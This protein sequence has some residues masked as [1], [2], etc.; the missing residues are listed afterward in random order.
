MTASTLP[1]ATVYGFASTGSSP[2]SPGSGQLAD[3]V[4]AGTVGASG[5]V[6]SRLS[7]LSVTPPL[8]AA[9]V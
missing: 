7:G 6:L 9:I 8:V 2:A 5:R 3:D 4:H 1:L